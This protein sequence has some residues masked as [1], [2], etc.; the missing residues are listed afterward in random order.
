MPRK[1]DSAAGPLP[2]SNCSC[3]M[4]FL[5][6]GRFYLLDRCLRHGSKTELLNELM[7]NGY[8]RAFECPCGSSHLR[9]MMVISRDVDNL[10][11]NLIL[12]E[13]VR[14]L[15][16]VTRSNKGFSQLRDLINQELEGG[17]LDGSLFDYWVR[18]FYWEGRPVQSSASPANLNKLTLN[19]L[20]ATLHTYNCQLFQTPTKDFNH[21]IAE[22]NAQARPERVRWQRRTMRIIIETIT[23]LVL[24][25]NDPGIPPKACLSLIA[26]LKRELHYKYQPVVPSVTFGWHINYAYEHDRLVGE[27][28]RQRLLDHGHTLY[29]PP[30]GWHSKPEGQL[31]EGVAQPAANYSRAMEYFFERLPQVALCAGLLTDFEQPLVARVGPNP[32]QIARYLGERHQIREALQQEIY[33]LIVYPGKWLESRHF[34]QLITRHL[35][36]HYSHNTQ[37]LLGH[38]NQLIRD[39]HLVEI[40]NKAS[41]HFW[42]A[43]IAL[44]AEYTRY[45]SARQKPSHSSQHHPNN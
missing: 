20:L 29:Q 12:P 7:R 40:L 32:F 9:S 5:L 42:Q 1:D 39:E 30:T 27:Q 8:L 3:S 35:Q 19:S 17:L 25:H 26:R 21:F 4:P 44:A 10:V 33:E 41:Q 18:V 28:S 43:H 14:R 31:I 23:G 13:Q 11:L 24:S 6:K 2:A 22:T 36:Q 37:P 45:Y 34:Q 38:I 15:A 16:E